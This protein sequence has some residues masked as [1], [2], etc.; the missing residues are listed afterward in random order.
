MIKMQAEFDRDDKIRE[1]YL[2]WEEDCLSRYTI[3]K[4]ELR[5]FLV[6]WVMG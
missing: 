4:E 2:E 6:N 1:E 3:S 5:V